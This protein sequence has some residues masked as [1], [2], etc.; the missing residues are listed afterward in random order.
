MEEDIYEMGDLEMV[1]EEE[2]RAVSLFTSPSAQQRPFGE[3]V[4][5]KI[6]QLKKHQK[7][8]STSMRTTVDAC[9]M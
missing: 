1:S 6:E 8:S 2:Q 4:F 5:E 9:V 7:C 3:V